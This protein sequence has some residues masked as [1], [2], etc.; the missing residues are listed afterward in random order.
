MKLV[1]YLT[2][3]RDAAVDDQG[4]LIFVGEECIHFSVRFD[5]GADKAGK[6]RIIAQGVTEVINVGCTRPLVEVAV[7]PGPGLGCRVGHCDVSCGQRGVHD[8]GWA[9]TSEGAT[10][11]PRAESKSGETKWKKKE[12]G[13]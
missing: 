5:D 1:R 11:S 12:G 7:G 10:R 4:T 8:K 13:Q 2:L 9:G 3:H 6:L